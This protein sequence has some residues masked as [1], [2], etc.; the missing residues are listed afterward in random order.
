MIPRHEPGQSFAS[1]Q[2]DMARWMGVSVAEMNAVHDDCHRAVC[3]WLGVDSLA[4]A[5]GRGEFLSG[6]ERELAG[7]EEEAICHLQRWLHKAGVRLP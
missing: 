5:D 4:L 6:R 2:A 3:A 7:L 1:H